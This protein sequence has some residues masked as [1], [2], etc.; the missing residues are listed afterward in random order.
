MQISL[1]NFLSIRLKKYFTKNLICPF[2]Q[3]EIRWA[4]F[5]R[6]YTILYALSQI[7]ISKINHPGRHREL[8]GYWVQS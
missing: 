4:G 3:T 5:F 7:S 6:F 2:Y 8:S 1:E